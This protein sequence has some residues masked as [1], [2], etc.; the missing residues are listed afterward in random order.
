MISQN[1]LPIQWSTNRS[2]TVNAGANTT[3]DAITASG[4]QVAAQIQLKAD[5][6]GAPQSGDTVDFFWLPSLG[7]IDATPQSADEFDTPGTATLL[8]RVD[9]NTEDPCIVTIPLPTPF[10]AG[11]VYAKNNSGGRNITVSAIVLETLA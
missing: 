5:N 10:K 2:V 9:T 7:D 11:K 4:T 3:S 6:A 1:L 8:A